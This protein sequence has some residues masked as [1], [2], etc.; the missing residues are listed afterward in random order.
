MLNEQRIAADDLYNLDFEVFGKV[1]KV[2]FRKCTKEKAETLNLVGNVQN[3]AKGTV[4]GL[5]QGQLNNID[6]FIQYL[7]FEGSP[8][9]IIENVNCTKSKI[10]N[11]QFK[12]FE[13]IRKKK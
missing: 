3:T 10:D 12:E 4:K 6:S 1:Q 11:L 2:F 13:I 5:A 8:K 7:K 9:S